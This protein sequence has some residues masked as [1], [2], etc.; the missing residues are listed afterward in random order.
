MVY[1]VMLLVS[2]IFCG[3]HIVLQI[4]HTLSHY[5]SVSIRLTR[6]PQIIALIETPHRSRTLTLFIS[7]LCV[8][9]F[10]HVRNLKEASIQLF[11]TFVF[12]LDLRLAK[13]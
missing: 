12:Y 1:V 11:S 4:K 8:P 6:S 9:K 3:Y 13:N 7:V 5:D 10:F 2:H